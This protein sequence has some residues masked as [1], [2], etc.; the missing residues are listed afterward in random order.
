MLFS[1]QIWDAG[2]IHFESCGL[3]IRNVAKKSLRNAN[4]AQR[5]RRKTK[6]NKRRS[7]TAS[8]AVTKLLVPSGYQ[9]TADG[10][11]SALRPAT[12]PLCLTRCTP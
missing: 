2:E 6:P 9:F 12:P 3:A 1:N 5:S 10:S 4:I 7:R 8:R 11:R